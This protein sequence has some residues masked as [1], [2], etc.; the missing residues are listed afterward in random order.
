[1]AAKKESRK[2]QPSYSRYWSSKKNEINKTQN[3]YRQLARDTAILESSDTKHP[4]ETLGFKVDARNKKIRLKGRGAVAVV[5][6]IRVGADIATVL[7]AIKA[8]NWKRV[9]QLVGNPNR[10][11][12]NYKPTSPQARKNLEWYN[13]KQY[14]KVYG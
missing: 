9:L 6:A 7:E 1:M 10:E 14:K 3:L 8:N 12:H 11:N 4:L 2:H 5:R 13:P